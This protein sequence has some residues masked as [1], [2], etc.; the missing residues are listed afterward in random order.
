MPLT[1]TQTSLQTVYGLFTIRVYQEAL[2]KETVVVYTNNL[3]ISQP[4]LARVHSECLT[5]DTFGSLYCDCGEQL[6]KSLEL[7]ER[8]GGVC[9]YL[10]QEGRGIGLF[11]KIKA[12]QL[13]REGY[14]TVE[15]NVM[16]GH[17]PDERTY[18]MAEQ[19]LRDL[20]ISSIRLLTNNPD[21]VSELKKYGINVVERVPLVIPAT[22]H[23]QAY[24]QTKKD[25]LH[26]L[27]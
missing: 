17:A 24:L 23:N 5:G 26:Q 2:G 25:K 11:E 12:Y 4:V 3:D 22:A 27:L 18:G 21:K 9:I 20:T 7:I 16:L 1:F 10:R 15:A 13:Q 8:E 6:K 19:A 14:D